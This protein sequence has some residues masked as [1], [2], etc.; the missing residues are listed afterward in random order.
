MGDFLFGSDG[1]IPP[2]RAVVAVVVV[3][4]FF[5]DDALLRDEFA[6]VLSLVV[7]S[8]ASYSINYLSS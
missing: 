3:A 1:T 6:A 2:T 5:V 4:F 7:L 8:L